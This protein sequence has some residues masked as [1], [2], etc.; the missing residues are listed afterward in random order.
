MSNGRVR[1]DRLPKA[2]AVAVIAIGTA[3]CAVLVATLPREVATHFSGFGAADGRMSRAGF[4]AGMLALSAGLPLASLFGLLALRSPATPAFPARGGYS[5]PRV[6]G[7]PA[8]GPWAACA[9]A[10]GLSIFMDFV[11]WSVWEANRAAPPSM[12]SASLG[13]GVAVFVAFVAAWAVAVSRRARG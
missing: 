11:A 8:V 3:L 1:S 13:P 12:P 4:A 5:A 9:F 6:K 2:C 7:A 10:A